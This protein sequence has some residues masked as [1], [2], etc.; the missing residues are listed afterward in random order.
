M[1]SRTDSI[2]R[3][4]SIRVKVISYS[5]KNTPDP[6]RGLWSAVVG[7]KSPG[8]HDS[9]VF[10][11]LRAVHKHR[12]IPQVFRKRR[13]IDV[14]C[15]RPKAQGLERCKVGAP[16]GDFAVPH[17]NF[18]LGMVFNWFG[19]GKLLSTLLGHHQ[20][21]HTGPEERPQP[22]GMGSDPCVGVADILVNLAA[23]DQS[24]QEF[25]V[26]T[27]EPTATSVGVGVVA[28]GLSDSVS[29]YVPLGIDANLVV[30]SVVFDFLDQLNLGHLELLRAF[31]PFHELNIHPPYR[32]HNI[33][34]HRITMVW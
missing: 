29:G 4:I 25:G 15:H 33:N 27:D 32:M 2:A 3:M 31:S 13:T 19:H 17:K 23:F 9:I 8:H 14:I 21:A 24:R 16:H 26:V 5:Q 12:G 18:I 10:G 1:L 20:R 6:L 22:G 11:Q 28:S 34:R 30:P 7:T